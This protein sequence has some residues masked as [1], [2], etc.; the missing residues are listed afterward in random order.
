MQN[1]AME[2]PRTRTKALDTIAVV[3]IDGDAVSVPHLL[4]TR[5]EKDANLRRV[6]AR[7]M[8]GG[9]QLAEPLAL[10]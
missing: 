8:S 3:W 10:K 9:D 2:V 6:Y 7:Q 4:D 5:I 1:F